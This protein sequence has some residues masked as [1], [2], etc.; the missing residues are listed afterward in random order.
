MT[1]F[2][3]QCYVKYYAYAYTYSAYITDMR[4]RYLALRFLDITDMPLLYLI[5][6]D[7]YTTDTHCTSKCINTHW[8]QYVPVSVYIKYNNYAQQYASN[9]L[10]FSIWNGECGY[11]S[12]QL[13]VRFVKGR[14]CIGHNRIWCVNGITFLYYYISFKEGLDRKGQCPQFR[15]SIKKYYCQY[16]IR[17]KKQLIQ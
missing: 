11:S 12:V 6:L 4:K 15:Y 13:L 17:L 7:T 9:P 14:K 3:L 8:I 1:N 10:Q 5:L 16:E 2:F